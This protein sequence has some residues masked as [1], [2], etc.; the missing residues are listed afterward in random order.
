[1]TCSQSDCNYATDVAK[2]LAD[3]IGPANVTNHVVSLTFNL[4][5]DSNT[6][7]PSKRE[8]K[9]NARP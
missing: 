2:N 5:W 3:M 6:P 4:C 7:G 1:M 9:T 8:S